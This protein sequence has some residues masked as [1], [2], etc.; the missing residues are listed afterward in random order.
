[1][2][3]KLFKLILNILII[4]LMV[5]S[6]SMIVNGNIIGIIF[7]IVSILMSVIINSNDKDNWYE[8]RFNE[9]HN[10]DDS[11]TNAAII[12]STYNSW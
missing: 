9:I 4:P 11:S 1:M 5:V 6:L 12:F 10:E 2:E 7:F 8:H 3:I